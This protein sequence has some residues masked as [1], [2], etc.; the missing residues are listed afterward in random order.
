MKDEEIGIPKSV[1]IEDKSVLDNQTRNADEELKNQINLA[2][3]EL[4][5]PKRSHEE[6]GSTENIPIVAEN[7]LTTAENVPL[8]SENI[9]QNIPTDTGSN[10]H[11]TNENKMTETKFD[12][13][14]TFP[15][16]KVVASTDDFRE[17]DN[18]HEKTPECGQTD[19]CGTLDS[20][21]QIHQVDD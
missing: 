6:S 9:G 16:N 20:E 7:V 12:G 3:N 14:M 1:K 8:T 11:E 19:S 13:S 10:T 4:A 5:V 15:K 21:T 18:K 2:K 17:N